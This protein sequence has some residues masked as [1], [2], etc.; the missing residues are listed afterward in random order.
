MLM[1]LAQAGHPLGGGGEGHPVPGLTGVDPEP[2]GQV[3]LARPRW[4]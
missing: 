1:G 4:A 3:R 2:R